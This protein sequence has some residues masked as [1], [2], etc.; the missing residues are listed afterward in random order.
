MSA[1]GFAMPGSDGVPESVGKFTIAVDGWGWDD[2]NPVQ[3]QGVT[4]LQDYFN[5][6]LLMRDEEHNIVSGL[7]TEWELNDEGFRFT[8]HPDAMWQTGK[9]I[10]AADVKWNYEASR[11]DFSPDFTGHLS[12]NRFMEQI[13]EVEIINE[14]EVF[15]KT[16]SPAPD[17]I[18]FYSGSGYHQVHVG[19]SAYLQE[20]GVAEFEKNPSGG[21]PYSVSLWKPGERIVLE[22]WDDFWGNT[23]TYHSPS[24]KLW[25]L[26]NQPIPPP[27]L[28]FSA[29]DRLMRW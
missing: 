13:Q 26:S 24:M 14:K 12:A 4:F 11:G 29:A 10:T 2:L 22:R 6:F 23:P 18:A 28:H 17:F 8:I 21:G 19:D 20:V 9:P 3:M 5:V 1:G 7:A 25:K 15:I 27:G 16:V